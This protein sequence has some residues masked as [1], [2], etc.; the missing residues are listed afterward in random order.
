[1]S[2]TEIDWSRYNFTPS[3]F[4]CR[5]IGCCG[6]LI[7]IHPGFLDRLQLLRNELG[8]PMHVLSGCRCAVHNARPAR[9][10]G[11]GGHARSLHVADHPMHAGQEGT[12]GV[13]IA[14]VDGY[15]RGRLFSIAW[16]HGWSV[17]WN[18]ARSFLHLDMRQWV[19][20]AQT[21]FDY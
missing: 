1:M 19:G 17:G 2:R 12:L 14:A 8:L 16:Q 21:S 11:A 3:E 20:L 18:A 6:G 13:D 10:G 5:G 9:L 7:R 4:R 15:Y